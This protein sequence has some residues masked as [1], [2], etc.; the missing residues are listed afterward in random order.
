MNKTQKVPVIQ[1][2]I[3]RYKKNKFASTFAL[4]GIVFDA[5]YLMLFYSINASNLYKILL[6]LSVIVNLAVL[7]FGFF[8]SEGIKNY[9]R[10][11]CIFLVILSLVQIVRI[12]IF[13]LQGLRGDYLSGHYFGAELNSTAMFIVLLVYLIASATC[14]MLSAV[15]G[16]IIAVKHDKHI[17]EVESGAISMEDELAKLETV[18]AA[19]DS[20][21][22]EEVDNG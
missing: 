13:P 10:K 18:E 14:F 11:F 16:Y 8:A 12:F 4:L 15:Q 19:S 21:V 22:N 6:G 7:L 1:N 20:S 17:K 9:E 5:L 3:L 2:D